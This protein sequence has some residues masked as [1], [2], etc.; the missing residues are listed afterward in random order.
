MKRIY[1]FSLTFLF[2]VF[3]K[4]I[5]Q[6][7]GKEI[8]LSFGVAIQPQDRRLFDYPLSDDIISREES[9]F[10]FHYDIELERKILGSKKF[11][12]N[13]GFGYSLLISKFSRPFLPTY[14]PHRLTFSPKV[15][16]RYCI[17]RLL[18][19]TT[20]QYDWLKK[21]NDEN[22]ISIIFPIKVN[23]DFN[24]SIRGLPGNF[25]ED[26]W[27][28]EFY[29]FEIFSGVRYKL[30]KVNIDITYRV[31]NLQAIDPVIFNYLLF[32]YRPAFL[33]KKNELLNLPNIVVNISCPIS[34]NHK[35]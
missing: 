24:K 12:I 33:D 27:K 10:D 20:L 17:H 19:S 30:G 14:F 8:Q 31:F 11:T 9:K 2:S 6:G 16:K 22:I 15:I 28:F 32:D 3:G 5:S 13:S 4:V 26:K 25:N 29:N 23:M 7:I 34:F 35:T 18:I 1:V 21:S